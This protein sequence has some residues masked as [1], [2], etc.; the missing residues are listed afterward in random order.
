MSVYIAGILILESVEPCLDYVEGR[1]WVKIFIIRSCDSGVEEMDWFQGSAAC[2]VSLPQEITVV[3]IIF[4]FTREGTGTVKAV[5][6]SRM[7]SV[8][9]CK[10][11]C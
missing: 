3:Y 6:S 1:K 4:Y 10:L 2:T 5:I 11:F 8:S 7:I 9:L